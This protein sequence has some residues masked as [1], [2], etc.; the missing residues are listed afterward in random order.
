MSTMSCNDVLDRLDDFIDDEL[1]TATTAA[2]GN[3]LRACPECR[4]EA[5]GLRALLERARSLP[6]SVPPAREL[7]PGIA[8]A[9]TEQRVV[10]GS[11]GKSRPAQPGPRL[12]RPNWWQALGVAAGLVLAS[13]V[14]IGYLLQPVGPLTSPPPTSGISLA[15]N[16]AFAAFAESEDDFVKARS[17]LL[18]ALEQRERSISPQTMMIVM[19]SMRILDESITGISAA[20]EQDPGSARL[21]ELL[22]SAYQREI[23]LLQQATTLPA[24]T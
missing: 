12:A 10:R 16:A 21:V 18:A 2:V 22:A 9:I 23:D 20:L 24:Q 7:W 15:T 6:A 19:D 8:A 3:H 1:S 13:T 4:S 17:E 14:L 5:E 11:F